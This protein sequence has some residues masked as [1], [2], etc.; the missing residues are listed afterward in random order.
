MA[1]KP[2]LRFR[3]SIAAWRLASIFASTFGSREVQARFEVA[4]GALVGGGWEDVGK[5]V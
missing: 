1:D 2:Q 4:A 5:R 3:R